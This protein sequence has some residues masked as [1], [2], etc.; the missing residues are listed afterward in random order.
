[1]RKTKE[2]ETMDKNTQDFIEMLSL[3][4][5][6][7]LENGM[8][9]MCALQAGFNDYQNRAVEMMERKTERSQLTFEAF[10]NHVYMKLQE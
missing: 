7:Y 10:C 9:A 8:S 1:M 5:E 2:R 3:Y 4:A 6:P